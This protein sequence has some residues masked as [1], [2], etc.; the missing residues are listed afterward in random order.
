MTLTNQESKQ[1]D[2]V[3]QDSAVKRVQGAL[4][5]GTIKSFDYATEMYNV[6]VDGSLVECQYLSPMLSRLVGIQFRYVLPAGTRVKV[7]LGPSPCIIG[8]MPGSEPEGV[9]EAKNKNTVT[10]NPVRSVEGDTTPQAINVPTDLLEGEL[11]LTSELKCGIQLLMGMA[12]LT[13]GE[14]AVVETIAYNDMVRI[15]SEVFRHHSAFGDEEIYNDGRLNKVEHGTSYDHEA[16]G[17]SADDEAKKAEQDDEG[18]PETAAGD[19]GRWRYSKYMGFLG[20]FIHIFVTDPTEAAGNMYDA[21]ARAGK[22]RVQIMNDGTL[23]AQSVS[24]IVIERVCRVTVPVQ[25]EKWDSPN[26]NLAKEMETL[27]TRFVQLWNALKGSRSRKDLADMAYQLR[28]YARWLNTY[29]SLSRF[30]QLSDDWDVPSEATQPKPSW[31]NKEKSVEDANGGGELYY[32]TYACIRIMRD[33]SIV[34]WSGDGSSLTMADGS[35]QLHASKHLDLRAAGDIRI[36]AGRDLHMHARRHADV[37]AAVGGFRIKAKCYLEALCEKGTLWLRSNAMDPTLD[38]YEAEEGDADNPAPKVRD[39]A[40]LIQAP[41][42]KMQHNSATGYKVAVTAEGIGLNED[43]PMIEVLNPNGSIDIQGSVTGESYVGITG[44]NI[45]IK[46]FGDLWARAFNFLVNTTKHFAVTGF[47]KTKL[48]VGPSGLT[49]LQRLKADTVDAR[50]ALLG[51]PIDVPGFPLRGFVGGSDRPATGD[52]DIPPGDGSVDD[53]KEWALDIPLPGNPSEFRD[54]SFGYGDYAAPETVRETLTDQFLRLSPP[55]DW[56][57]Q[58]SSWSPVQANGSA[59]PGPYTA[60]EENSEQHNPESAAV[61]LNQPNPTLPANLPT[62][63][64]GYGP[65]TTR[66]NYLKA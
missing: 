57:G 60:A 47:G 5:D 32:D 37:L 35:V 10:G 49:H 58:F 21:A 26:G 30:L 14:Q 39:Q 6:D 63:A 62:E 23:L 66:W 19:A 12:R 34:V 40:V 52:E 61:P 42:G 28:E 1:A 65:K 48:Y 25:K 46:A 64:S 9:T 53:L 20:D 41:S 11:D 56:D 22:A 27:D 45:F 36:H 4:Y 18:V 55:A 38:A 50:Q 29:H 8:A 59:V 33:G 54:P 31:G 51:P 44:S 17:A 43:E 24:D 2:A 15:V 16:W 13:A 3:G 7:V